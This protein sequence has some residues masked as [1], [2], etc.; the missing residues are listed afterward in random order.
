MKDWT[1]KLWLRILLPTVLVVVWFAIAGLGGPTFGKISEV[2]TN[3]QAGFL[4]ASAQST[5]VNEWQTKF[6]DSEAIPAI[7]VFQKDSGE[8]TDA[9]KLKFDELTTTLENTEGVAP[10]VEGEVPSVL[11]PTY[12]DDNKAV[13]YLVFFEASGEELL[14]SIEGLRAELADATPAGF[15]GYV[16]GPG[17]LLADFVSGFAGIDGILLIVALLAVF[18]ILLVVYRALLLPILVLLTS[19]FALSGSILG[20]YYLALNDI[21]KV[22]GQSQGIL[23]ILVIG[24]ATDYALLFVARYREALFEVQNKWTALGRAFRGSFEPIFAS[25]AT[26]IAALLCLLFS[27]LNSN[28]SLGPIAAFGIGFAFLAAISFLPA[29]LAIFGRA[30][31]WPFMPKPGKKKLAPVE[32]N[33]LPGLEGVRGLWKSVGNLVGKKPRA[34]W[35]ITLV[36]LLAAVAGLPGLKA[37]G[38]PQTELLLGDNIESVDGQEV[39]AQHF[40]AGDGSPVIIIADEAKYEDV[41]AAAEATEGIS[42]ASVQADATAMAEAY[43]K[44]IADAAAKAAAA[45]AAAGVAGPPAGVMTGPPAGVATDAAPAFELPEIAPIPQVVD[46]KVLINATLTYQAD[47]AAAENVVKQMRTDLVSVDPSVL[48]GGETAIALD[49]NQTAQAD[50]VKIIPIVLLV[51]FFILMLLLRSV[52][53]PLLLIFTVVVSFAATMGLAAIF[54]NNVFGF[55]GADASVPLFG[56]VFLVALGIDYNIFLMTRVREE[57]INLGTRPGILKGLTVTG[58]VITSAGIV[59]AATFAAL[60]VIPLLFLVQLAFI[61][62]VG[63]IIDTVLVRT[64]LVPALAYDIGPKIWWPSK[65]GREIN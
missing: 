24:A 56:F 40:D 52:V 1:P 51:I 37:N 55:P 61:V 62:S 17:G 21:I 33:T 32:P 64:L 65:L 59:L 31:F 43:K 46:G 41:L 47:S 4:P 11:G 3:D 42:K 16:T 29:L 35:I 60:G 12:S 23:S 15:T 19:V 49:T 26:V 9:D 57:S 34:T 18:I 38:I 44:A 6:N 58:G 10:S 36:V 25:A 28:K 2:S 7:V 45:A 48:V 39:L 14:S 22:N 13:E 53:A 20:I 5:E 50:L 63:V 27:D 8:V 30:A 54:F